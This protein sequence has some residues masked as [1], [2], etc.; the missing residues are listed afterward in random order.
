[1]T[2]T[3]AYQVGAL[4]LAAAAM[5]VFSLAK[6]MIPRQV[7]R[8][9]QIAL[10]LLGLAVLGM[11]MGNALPRIGWPSL[12]ALSSWGG[13]SKAKTTIV[14]PS[15]APA[16]TARSKGASRIRGKVREISPEEA[17]RLMEQIRNRTEIPLGR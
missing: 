7:R 16:Q 6:N 1:M 9:G 14:T 13:A 11:A 8:V 3:T 10:G 15:P 17:E 12:P 2:P 5:M 4:L